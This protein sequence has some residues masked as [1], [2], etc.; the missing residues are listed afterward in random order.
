MVPESLP[1]VVID[2]VGFVRFVLNPKGLWGAIMTRS[3][4]R[5]R[6]RWAR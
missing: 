6:T 4:I 3:K 5:E 2:T 1:V